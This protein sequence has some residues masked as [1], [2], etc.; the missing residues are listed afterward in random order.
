MPV[1]SRWQCAIPQ[2]SF[3]TYVFTSP[4]HP[5]P[6]A[7]LYID[8]LSPTNHYLTTH[9]YRS[10][11]VRIASGLIS[12]GL[13]P[14]DRV[15]LYSGN[16]I[17]FPTV[18][19]G[20]IAAGGIFTGANP[21]FTARELAYQLKDSEAEFLLVNVGSID[22]GIEAAKM[23]GLDPEKVFVFD[24]GLYVDDEGG[25]VKWTTRE[26]VKGVRHW[27]DIVMAGND[28][29]AWEE[30]STEE[31]VNRTA[32]INYSSGTTGVPKGVEITHRNFVANAQQN[33]HVRNQSQK[34]YVTPHWLCAIP[35][36]HAYGQT[37]YATIAPVRK[38]TTWILPKFDFHTFLSCVEQ[39]KI[40]NISGV[41][42]IM[43]ALAK[44]PEVA[45]YNLSSVVNLG[46][47]A[48]PLSREISRAVEGRVSRGRGLKENINLKQGWGMTEATCSVMGFHPDDRDEDGSIGE[49]FPNCEGKIM[50]AET[51]TQEL[52]VGEKGEIWVRGPNVM[53]GYYKNSKATR[54]TITEDGWLKTGDIGYYNE[55]KKWFIVDRKKEL[56]K[57]KGNQVAPAE[58]EGLLL[59]NPGIADA[60]VIGIAYAEDERPRAYIVL[61]PGASLIP[62][63]VK[64]WVSERASRHKWLTGGVVIVKDVPRN[65]SGKILKKVLRERAKTEVVDTADHRAKL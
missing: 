18:F 51:G 3:P 60:A 26:R 31:E 14:G 48:A 55:R 42:P 58:L 65:P 50:D 33:V 36:Y 12:C 16:N 7:P 13:F 5:L 61:K 39:F 8:A 1:K 56:I 29:F 64:K 22:V 10:T 41:P 9:S 32:A 46:C 52:S 17:Y 40:T 2:C 53:K 37:Y 47:G 30:L 27:S 49:V 15:L 43:V 35:M 54:E 6:K 57:V 63:D 25:I 11:V 44:H 23:V 34:P 4:T 38:I 20:I 45:K 62:D 19:T 59:E 28:K 24:D 21:T